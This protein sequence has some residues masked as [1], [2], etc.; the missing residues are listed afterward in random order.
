MWHVGNCGVHV[1]GKMSKDIGMGVRKGLSFLPCFLGF[2][3]YMSFHFL[4]CFFVTC[5]SC[6]LGG[7]G[8]GYT[9]TD[10][11]PIRMYSY[12]GGRQREEALLD[13]GYCIHTIAF[14]NKSNCSA[15]ILK[16]SR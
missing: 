5:F 14:S 15:V 3:P 9:A 6:F 4:N 7:G 10:P 2:H 8:G 12:S 16:R 13:L 1:V 11:A